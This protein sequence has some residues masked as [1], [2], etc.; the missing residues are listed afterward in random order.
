ML[1]L[2]LSFCSAFLLGNVWSKITGTA[3]KAVPSCED[4]DNGLNYY[5]KGYGIGKE[6]NTYTYWDSC[7]ENQNPDG[8]TPLIDEYYCNNNSELYHI[9]TTCPNGTTCKDG[10]CSPEN[11]NCADINGELC[12]NLYAGSCEGSLVKTKDA[13][14]SNDFCCMGKCLT[15]TPIKEE[16]NTET[17]INKSPAKCIDS[18]NYAGRQNVLGSVNIPEEQ[19]AY[20]D[21]CLDNFTLIERTCKDDALLDVTYNCSEGCSEGA[22]ILATDITKEK[23]INQPIISTIACNGCIL[24]EKCYTFGYRKN[25]QF[26][27][28]N[29]NFIAQ[30][31]TDKNCENN[32]ECSSNVC[33]SGKCI[34]EGFLQKVLS[35]FKRLF[36]TE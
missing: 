2:S 28:D 22:C 4:S 1:I 32:F 15:N 34:S 31:E 7:I 35:W 21:Y 6:N 19:S 11:L 30:L 26:C 13:V 14:N 10:A 27:S 33:V 18:D 24:N 25:N 8:P 5:V 16:N 12:K 3:V 20:L 23:I 36:G 9:V 29:G 17:N